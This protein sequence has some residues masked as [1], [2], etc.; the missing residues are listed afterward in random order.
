MW[1]DPQTV[2]DDEQAR[3]T[4]ARLLQAR[5]EHVAA[6]LV[7]VSNYQDF[8]VDNRDGGQYEAELA[9]PP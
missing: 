5:G 2:P 9:A 3:H 8:C 4:M 6:A 7:A 1:G